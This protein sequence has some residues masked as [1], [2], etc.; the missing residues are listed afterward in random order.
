MSPS[1]LDAVSRYPRTAGL[2]DGSPVELVRFALDDREDMLA[3][4]RSLDEDV[5]LFL[6]EDITSPAT[7]DAWLAEVESGDTFTVLARVEGRLVGYSSLHTEPARWSR[8]ARWTSH[9]G[10]VRINVHADYR[11]TGMGA[12]L[13]SEIREIAPAL[14]VRKLS[15]QMTVDQGGARVVFERLGFRYQATLEEWVIDRD[16]AARDLVIM[17]CDIEAG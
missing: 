12:L 15:A 5:L 4:T 9:I 8:P 14:G 17:S 3:F 7:M 13:A 11:G 16:G 6:R 1:L 2:R 10:E